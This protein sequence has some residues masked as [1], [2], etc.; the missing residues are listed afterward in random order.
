[1]EQPLSFRME[2]GQEFV[3]A[4]RLGRGR[5]VILTN[6]TKGAKPTRRKKAPKKSAEWQGDPMLR[7]TAR[8]IT[9]HT[10]S[11]PRAANV[12]ELLLA[13]KKG[14]AD[15]ATLNLAVREAVNDVIAK[16]RS[17]GIDIVN[18][19]EQGRT[20]YTVHVVDRLT[21]FEGQSTPPLGH[22]EPEFPELAE[23]LKQF[24]SPFQHRPACSGPVGWKDF[25]ATE[26]D[27][28]R[29]KAGMVKAG[30]AEYFMTSPSPGQ[31]ARY[32]KNNHYKTDEE[33]LFALAD[34]MKR[35]YKAIV[36]AGFIVQ[37]DCPDLAMSYALY[38]GISLADYRKIIAMNVEALNVAIKDLPADR[39][40]M[41]VCWG[42]TLG[43]HHGDIPL[44]DIVDIVLK[45]KPMAV[46]FPGANPRHG[47]EW[48]VWQD[49]KLPDGKAIVPG[50]I[51]STSNFVEHPELVA[52]RLVQ[53]AGAV[54]REN[55]IAGVDCGFGTFAGR[56]QVDTKI[57]WM[58]LA[59]LAEGARLASKQ[60]WN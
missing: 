49:V 14:D 13:E 51:D 52:D 25:H 57:V 48:K 8:I 33:Y 31:I 54:G 27:I 32:L 59:S 3:S 53:Y 55:V 30:V 35:E 6:P 18:D 46:S 40:R 24:A 5:I 34:V 43:P 42:S 45:A 29:A 39:M 10:G 44:K 23:L 4:H 21:G 11:L 58:K 1:M 15:R 38:P 28:A 16:Q 56:V 7:S 36:D 2:G 50:V 17:A 12:V 47:H 22:G 60:L 19:G 41:H 37:L 9:T 26:A 20:D